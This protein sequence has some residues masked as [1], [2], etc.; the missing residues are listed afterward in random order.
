MLWFAA[1]LLLAPQLRFPC[2]L[3]SSALYAVGVTAIALVCQIKPW[4][5]RVALPAV[6]GLF[7]GMALDMHRRRAFLRQQQQQQQQPSA[8]AATQLKS[9]MQKKVQ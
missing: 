4:G 1:P 5:L 6:G 3:L 9:G 7:I 2:L 8:T